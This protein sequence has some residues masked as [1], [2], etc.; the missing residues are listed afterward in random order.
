LGVALLCFTVE[1]CF[2]DDLELL[3]PV[4]FSTDD[5]DASSFFDFFALP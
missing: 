3:S 4:F 5:P 1:V 2:T